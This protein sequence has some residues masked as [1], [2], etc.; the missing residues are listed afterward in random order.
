V[1]L[2]AK[3]DLLFATVTH[4]QPLDGTI[5]K[6][7]DKKDSLL[8]V[9]HHPEI[10]LHNNPAELGARARVRKRDVSFGPRTSEGAKAW[11]TFMSLAESAKKLGVSFHD[12]VHDRILGTN[13]VPRLDTL[14]TARAA[15]LPLSPSW[16]NS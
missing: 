1:R 2:S 5:A 15:T 6:T 9:L 8:M 4:Y 7:R 10:E 16:I 14:L 13:R 3:F 11:D 12:Y